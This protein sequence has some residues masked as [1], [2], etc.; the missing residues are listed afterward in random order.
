MVL[1]F[2]LVLPIV[3]LFCL[4]CSEA[5]KAS[6]PRRKVLKS[7]APSKIR[8]Q[9]YHP[10]GSIGY[11]LAPKRA[12]GYSQKTRNYGKILDTPYAPRVLVKHGSHT[13][14][15]YGLQRNKYLSKKVPSYAAFNKGL[16]GKTYVYIPKGKF[17]YAGLMKQYI[18]SKG[19]KK[20]GLGKKSKSLKSFNEF[21]IGRKSKSFGGSLEFRGKGDRVGVH[22]IGL[23][24]DISSFGIDR[25][26]G[27]DN[28]G[29]GRGGRQLTGDSNSLH[30]PV[31]N[32]G[33]FGPVGIVGSFGPKESAVA[34][35]GGIGSRFS[36]GGGENFFITD[37]RYEVTK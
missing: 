35:G 4:T 36:G 37:N 20:F 26:G 19:S 11:Q 6:Y 15:G 28:I 18:P 1:Y 17:A 33:R 12:S 30:G 29:I 21:D 23:G 13:R 10:K 8:I 3:V 27:I 34:F 32:I 25:R 14:N 7:Y 31:G 5:H 16:K 9:A 22:N 2:R 24:A